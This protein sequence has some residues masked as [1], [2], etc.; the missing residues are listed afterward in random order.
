MLLWE[1]SAELVQSVST[2]LEAA[3]HKEQPGAPL[4][5]QVCDNVRAVAAGHGITT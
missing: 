5:K 4:F 2:Y 3:G 1:L